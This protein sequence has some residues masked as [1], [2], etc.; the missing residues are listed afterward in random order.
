MSAG[1]YVLLVDD[2]DDLR[3]CLVDVLED[4]GFL[5][6]T[7]SSGREA[8]EL[9]QNPELPGLILL[10]LM[11]PDLNGWQFYERKQADPRLAGIPVLVVTANRGMRAAI[12]GL[13]V[14]LK[15]FTAEAVLSKV[16]DLLARRN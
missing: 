15:P 8:L 10:D 3:Q 6:Q 12:S 2:D 16:Q 9:L 1:P 14:L 4:E 11:M 13:D 5:T 7:A